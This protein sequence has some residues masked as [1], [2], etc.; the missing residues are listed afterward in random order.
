MRV[1]H[2]TQVP[3]RTVLCALASRCY[4]AG[5]LSLFDADLPRVVVA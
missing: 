4:F 5:F 3:V 1:S 2:F